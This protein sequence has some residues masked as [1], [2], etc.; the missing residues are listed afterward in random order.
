MAGT[1]NNAAK[2]EII[3]LTKLSPEQLLQIRQEFEQVSA[4]R[5]CRVGVSHNGSGG[6]AVPWCRTARC[7]LESHM[8]QIIGIS[9]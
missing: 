6:R 3:D 1:S 9:C 2:P 5:V 4:S 8:L 7:T